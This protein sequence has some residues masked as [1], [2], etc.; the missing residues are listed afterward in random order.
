MQCRWEI[1]PE[2]HPDILKSVN[3]IRKSSLLGVDQ[4]VYNGYASKFED[5]QKTD[6]NV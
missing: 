1:S 6:K 5:T 4:F 2:G 3:A